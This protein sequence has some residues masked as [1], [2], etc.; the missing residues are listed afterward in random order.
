MTYEK[1]FGYVDISRYT[2]MTSDGVRTGEREET[3]VD[4]EA[5]TNIAILTGDDTV[6]YVKRAAFVMSVENAGAFLGEKYNYENYVDKESDRIEGSTEV[7]EDKSTEEI[8]YKVAYAEDENN[9]IIVGKGWGH[10]VGMSQYGA[11]DLALLGKSAK[12]I[13]NAYFTDIAIIDYSSAKNFRR[14]S[15]E[16]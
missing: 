15:D 7:I 9:F 12:E 13:L 10:G 5:Q 4:G 1:D 8:L 11:Y 14:S 2:V 6:N 16:E 3:E